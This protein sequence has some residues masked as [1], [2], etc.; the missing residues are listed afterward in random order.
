MSNGRERRAP[1]RPDDFQT[2]AWALDPLWPHLWLGWHIWEPACGKGNLVRAMDERGFTVTG[3]DITHGTDF[4]TADP[5][6]FNCLITNPPYSIKDAWIERCYA[7]EKPFALLMPFTALEGKRRQAMFRRYG[8][9]VIVLPSR[10][11]FETPTG[12]TDGRAWFPTFWVTWGLDIGSALTFWQEPTP[13]V[14]MDKEVVVI[15]RQLCIFEV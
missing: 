13:E 2:P 6:P 14:I 8:I 12:R 3:T 5:P 15:D 4:L 10:I 11:H 9:E 7:L 1:G